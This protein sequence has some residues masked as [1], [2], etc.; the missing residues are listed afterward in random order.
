MIDPEAHARLLAGYC[1]DVQP[2]QQVLV[3]AGVGAAPLMLA[4]QREILERGGWPLLRPSL[5]GQDES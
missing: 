3:R 2:G 5:E 4:L 1:L